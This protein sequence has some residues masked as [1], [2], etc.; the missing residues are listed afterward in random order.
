MKV[1]NVP[2]SFYPEYLP[3]SE[4]PTRENQR[5]FFSSSPGAF[6]DIFTKTDTYTKYISIYMDLSPYIS[7]E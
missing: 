4:S 7:K 6:A 3:A 1:W 2:E 5:F